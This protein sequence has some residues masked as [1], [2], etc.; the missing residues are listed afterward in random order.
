MRSR[1]AD[2]LRDRILTGRLA[3]GTRIEVR[4]LFFNTPAR[5][6]FLK[7]DGTGY[8]SDAVRALNY[9]ISNG[10][11]IVNMSWGGG[12]YNSALAAEIF[13]RARK[14]T[15]LQGELP[16]PLAPPAGDRRGAYLRWLAW[17]GNTLHGAYRPLNVPQY[18]TDDEADR[19]AR[20][21][22]SRPPC[23]PRPQWCPPC[24][25]CLRCCP[26]S[27]IPPSARRPSCRSTARS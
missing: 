4:D 16:S 21:P 1:A 19:P 14:R 6:K 5:L 17:L 13:T 27:P 23:H 26:R 18:L 15:V 8:T 12:A 2:E 9:A 20:S 7:G 10:A 11:R 25:H 22:G 3:P 24:P